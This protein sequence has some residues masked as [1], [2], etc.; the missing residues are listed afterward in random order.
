MFSHRVAVRLGLLAAGIV[1]CGL[2]GSPVLAGVNPKGA[3]ANKGAG[4]RADHE[5]IHE[6]RRVREQLNHAKHDYKGHREKAVHFIDKAIHA[7]REDIE[8]KGGKNGKPNAGGKGKGLA[9]QAKGE[10]QQHSDNILRHAIKEL[11][12][13][14]H[15]LTHLRQDKQRHR[16]EVDIHHAIHELEVALSIK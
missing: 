13:I 4:K 9:K 6:L 5:L 14:E 3:G 8:A 15:Q 2:S 1:L 7:L 16:A 10:S 12:H 11:K